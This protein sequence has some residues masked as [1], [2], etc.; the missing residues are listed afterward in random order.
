MLAH[1]GCRIPFPAAS[2]QSRWAHCLRNLRLDG[3]DLRSRTRVDREM[4]GE[5]PDAHAVP[6]R[7]TNVPA[8]RPGRGPGRSGA[9]QRLARTSLCDRHWPAWL[10]PARRCLR[11]GHAERPS[12]SSANAFASPPFSF[13]EKWMGWPNDPLCERGNEADQDISLLCRVHQDERNI[14]A[15]IHACVMMSKR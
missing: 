7:H 6:R 5:H 12:V 4:Q 11:S 15:G 8:L 3:T 13:S 2:R 1:R 14:L 9:R 10:H